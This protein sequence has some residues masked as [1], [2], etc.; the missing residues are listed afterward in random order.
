V[1]DGKKENAVKHIRIRA[2]WQRGCINNGH[3]WFQ[4]GYSAIIRHLYR[5]RTAL[6]VLS[7][8]FRVPT[9]VVK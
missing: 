6:H 1:A 3:R 8:T 5:I 7:G 4:I 9:V 2:P